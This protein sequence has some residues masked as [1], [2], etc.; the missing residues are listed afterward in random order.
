MIRG[1]ESRL[2][3]FQETRLVDSRDS[4]KVYLNCR[5]VDFHVKTGQSFMQYEQRPDSDTIRTTF[6]NRHLDTEQIMLLLA[7]IAGYKYLSC[8][9]DTIWIFFDKIKR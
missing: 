9:Y 4:R 7:T 1:E 8:M 5:H 6:I 2:K 3:T